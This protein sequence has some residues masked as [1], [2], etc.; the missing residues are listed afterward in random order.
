MV[1][2]SQGYNPARPES[3]P[4]QDARWALIKLCWSSVDQR[5]LA[6][7]VV[8]SLQDF[9][10]SCPTSLPLCDFLSGIQPAMSDVPVMSS[11]PTNEYGMSV[12]SDYGASCLSS[13]SWHS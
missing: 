7:D 4:I 2:L 11:S 10:C 13:K 6:R 5:P 1:Q 3:R 12:D 9:L 8:S